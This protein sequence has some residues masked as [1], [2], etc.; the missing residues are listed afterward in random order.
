MLLVALIIS[1]NNNVIV[2][3]MKHLKAEALFVLKS[4]RIFPIKKI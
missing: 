1:K 3:L 4:V 2:E